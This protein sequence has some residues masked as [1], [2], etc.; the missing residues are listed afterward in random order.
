[1]KLK[2]LILAIVCV[3]IAG[4]VSTGCDSDRQKVLDAE[5]KVRDANKSLATI[6]GEARDVAHRERMQKEWEQYKKEC[7]LVIASNDKQI[8][9]L[10]DAVL[11]NKRGYNKAYIERV[12]DLKAENELI[13]ARIEEYET[14]ADISKWEAF[15][16]EINHDMKNLTEAFKDLAINN[17]N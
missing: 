10:E 2:M 4:A 5:Q 6:Q 14:D 17:T 9:E 1:M 3:T 15:K 12:N 16:T 11:K 8:A 7:E 13:R